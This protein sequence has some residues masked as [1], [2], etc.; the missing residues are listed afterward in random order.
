MKINSLD[1]AAFVSFPITFNVDAT[2]AGGGD[3]GVRVSGPKDVKDADLSVTPSK[4]QGL[5]NVKYIPRVKGGHQFHVSWAGKPVP[6]SPF[7]VDVSEKKPEVQRALRADATN[8]VEVG[9]PA[10]VSIVNL[11]PELDEGYVTAK[12]SGQNSGDV[13]VPVEKQESGSY[14]VHFTPTAADDYN[15][16]VKMN[17]EHVAGSPF[18]VKAVEKGALSPDYAHPD[19]PAQSDVQAGK[20]VNVIARSDELPDPSSLT[21]TTTGPYGPCETLPL[22]ADLEGAVGL[23]F[24]PPLSGDYLVTAKKDGNEAVGSPYKI[25]AT[26]KDPDPTKVCIMDDDKGVFSKVIPFGRSAKFR[27]STT[28]AGPGTLNITSRGPG[29]AQVKVFDN[30]DGTYTCEFTPSIAGKYHIDVLWNSEHIQG[31]PYLLTS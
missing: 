15:L 31:S 17:N 6:G 3:L 1:S 18:L 30:K 2:A 21:V 13:E 24:L 10:N 12:C 29:K 28:D 27:V 7:P 26:G 9:Q 25:T 22:N 4:T 8:L 19:G 5:Y 23:G 14:I 11:S 16:E 20:P